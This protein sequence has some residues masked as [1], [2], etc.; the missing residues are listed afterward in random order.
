MLLS[1][2]VCKTLTVGV[3]NLHN[4]GCCNRQ[5]NFALS[6]VEAYQL[7]AMEL[8]YIQDIPLHLSSPSCGPVVGHALK[9]MAFGVSGLLELN[10]K[11][12]SK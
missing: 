3:G 11:P 1:S 8:G 7:S 2:P 5:R 9:H 12:C 4:F 6:T 10:V